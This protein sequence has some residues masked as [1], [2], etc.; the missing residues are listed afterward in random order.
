MQLHTAVLITRHWFNLVVQFPFFDGIFSSNFVLFL[1]QINRWCTSNYNSLQNEH[2][3]VYFSKNISA[4]ANTF[5]TFQLQSQFDEQDWGT[6]HLPL[7]GRCEKH[8]NV[9]SL[10]CPGRS[11]RF[12]GGIV[13]TNWTSADHNTQ[14]RQWEELRQRHGK[15]K[16][17]WLVALGV[18]ANQILWH[19]LCKS[20]ANTIRR[21]PG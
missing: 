13:D 4:Q 19:D 12:F 15:W 1:M 6:L 14:L 5:S 20:T 7:S 3:S 2:I 18:Q 16:R 8:I 10:A 11:L 9:V 21:S 17:F